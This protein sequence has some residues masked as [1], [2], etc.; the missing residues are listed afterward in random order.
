L[1]LKSPNQQVTVTTD[2]LTYLLHGLP[3]R[4]FSC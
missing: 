3:D 1:I 4:F 2:L